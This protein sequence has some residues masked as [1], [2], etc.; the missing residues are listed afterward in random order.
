MSDVESIQSVQIGG[1]EVDRGTVPLWAGV[2]GAPAVWSLQLQLGYMMVPWVCTNGHL[3]V[4]HA[5]T[6]VALVLAAVCFGLCF[7]EHRRVGP[8]GL[9]GEEGGFPGRTRFL[10]VLG[11]LVSST[12]FLLILAQGLPSFF[13]NPCWA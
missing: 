12:F 13:L 10:A 8:G 11:M 9:E 6:I 4:L 2:L 7:L 3:W 1:V 5:I